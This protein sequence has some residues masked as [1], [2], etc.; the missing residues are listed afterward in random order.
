MADRF[1]SLTARIGARAVVR[2]DEVLDPAFADECLDALEQY[3]VLV[4]PRIGLTDDEQVSFSENLGEVIPM[5][6]MRPD[7]TR[8][9][10]YEVTLDPKQ[11]ASAEYLKGTIGWHIDG[12]TGEGPPP[13]A[14]TLSARRLSPTGGQT[15]FCS[16]YAAYDDLPEALRSL[17]EPL[18]LVHSLEASKRNT[19]PN[20]T[21]EE[22]ARSRKRITPKLHPLVWHHDSGRRSLVLGTTVDYVEGMGEAEGRALLERLTAHATRPENVYRHEW[23]IGDLVLWNNCGVMHRVIPYDP[24]SGRL[25]HR[26]TLY[27]VERIKGVERAI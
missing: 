5:G 12:M 27:G 11:S 10:V 9:V 16:T 23:Q 20:A 6:P 25:M 22:L 19:D 3:G 13:R 7:G 21:P 18:R 2:G 8:E 14:T 24:N 17:C 4:F 1:L 26:T 15:E